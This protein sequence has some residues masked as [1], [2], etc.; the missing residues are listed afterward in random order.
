MQAPADQQH[1]RG[2]QQSAIVDRQRLGRVRDHVLHHNRVGDDADHDREVAEGEQVARGAPTLGRARVLEGVLGD[3][4]DEREVDPPQHACHRRSCDQT[5]QNSTREAHIGCGCTDGHD[6]FAERD[7]HEQG[8]ALGEVHRIDRPLAGGAAYCAGDVDQCRG[9]PPRQSGVIVGEA[10]G[11]DAQWRDRR[12]RHEVDECLTRSRVS[13]RLGA[14]HAEHEQLH[15]HVGNAEPRARVGRAGF[16]ERVGDGHRHRQRRRDGAQ[17]QHPCGDALLEIGRRARPGELRPLPPHQP[18]DQRPARRTPQREVVA[19][20]RGDLRDGEDEDEVEEELEVGRVAFGLVR[21][22]RRRYRWARNQISNAAAHSCSYGTSRPISS[23]RS[24][25]S[26][27]NAA[28]RSSAMVA[29]TR[30]GPDVA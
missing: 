14:L 18:R 23:E 9:D 29:C 4:R 12:H 19:D 6:R 10:S 3:P 22:L 21:H 24:S 26:S 7:D 25:R 8:V 1:H 17:H 13:H 20:E 28:S 30:R 5:D 2:D 15:R 11:Q 27:P 16:V